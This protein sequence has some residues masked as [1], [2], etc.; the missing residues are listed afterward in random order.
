MFSS[1]MTN[2]W[3]VGTLVALLAGATGFFVVLR[4][5]SFAAHAVPNGAFAGAAGATLVGVAP[6][7][8]LV[9]FAVVAA[10]GIGASR[11]H[12][13]DVATAMALVLMLA[14]GAA[15]LSLSAA[16]EP[17]VQALLFGEILGVA[18]SSI[19]TV[20][21]IGLVCAAALAVMF[22]PL[23]FNAA[24]PDLSAARGLNPTLLEMGFM[25]TLALGSALT[26]PVVGAL[27]SFSLTVGPPAAAR[28]LTR[29]PSTALVGS[30]ALSVMT[31]WVSIALSYATNLP[32]GFF[33]GTLSA[34]LY[35]AVRAATQLS[36]RRA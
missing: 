35:I 31:L 9:S 3:I 7:W 24:A 1:F 23:I 27:L 33:V 2:A 26:V 16:Y 19:T 34:I 6:L 21:L 32:V 12:R 5:S 11:R 4:G 10:L 15:F 14:L 18:S 30:M 8:G 25:L 22:R 28:L 20:V 13:S 36:A 29:R 17:Q